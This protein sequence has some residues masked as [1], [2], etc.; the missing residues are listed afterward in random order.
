MA[1]QSKAFTEVEPSRHP[2]DWKCPEC[3]KGK[4]A[5]DPFWVWKKYGISA[6]AHCPKC[7]TTMPKKVVR[8]GDWTKPDTAKP[9]PKA[10]AKAAAVA[11]PSVSLTVK[12]QAAEIKK[13]AAEI[14]KLKAKAGT[15]VGT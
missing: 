5:D 9:Q 8:F 12:N 7:V 2:M 1:G 13:Q 3:S 4:P 14:K 11:P 6:P 10:K 15:S